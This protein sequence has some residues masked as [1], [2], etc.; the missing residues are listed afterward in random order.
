[1]KEGSVIFLFHDLC[2]SFSLSLSLFLSH[3]LSVSVSL[4]LSLTHTVSLSLSIYH[5]PSLSL[6]LSLSLSVSKSLVDLYWSIN[7]YRSVCGA[8]Y[9]YTHLCK[10]QGC[11]S[12]SLY[13]VG[14]QI[15]FFKFERLRDLIFIYQTFLV[16]FTFTNFSNFYFFEVLIRSVFFGSGEFQ[17]GS[18]TRYTR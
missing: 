3:Y 7:Q 5:T 18:V 14:I 16:I 9:F 12:G 15:L 8:L 2:I 10:Y 1:M 6:W 4:S 17:P 13:L 11:G